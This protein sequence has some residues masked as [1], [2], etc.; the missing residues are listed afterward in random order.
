MVSAERAS[1]LILGGG[2]EAS[3]IISEPSL[4]EL[5]CAATAVGRC[6]FKGSQYRRTPLFRRP[7][8]IR[9]CGNAHQPQKVSRQ[10]R[11]LP[12]S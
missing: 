2:E 8:A 10:S 7:K 5:H 6:V 3:R 4:K 9:P 11:G 12:L 1:S